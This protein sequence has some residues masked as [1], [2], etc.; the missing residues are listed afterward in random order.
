MVPNV[1]WSGVDAVSGVT[2]ATVSAG[3]NGWFPPGGTPAPQWILINLGTNDLAGIHTGMTEATWLSDMG[4]LLDKL[5]THWPLAQMR[6]M[7]VY[8]TDYTTEQNLLDDTW[9]PDVLS[10]RAAFAAV[11]P[12]ERTFL[13]GHVVDYTHPD[14]TGYLLTANGWK[15]VMGY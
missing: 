4:G 14:A 15:Q 13:P 6:L 12:D 10:T 7:R 8:N 11:G 1:A 3:I 2:T 9:I 5:H